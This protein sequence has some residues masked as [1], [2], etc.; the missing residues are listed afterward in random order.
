MIHQHTVTE[1][2]HQKRIDKL[3]TGLLS[4]TSRSQ[5]QS[6]ITDGYV[7]VNGKN[8]KTNYKCQT[9]DVVEWTVP[10]PDSLTIEAEQIPLE[11]VYEDNYLL[12]VNKPRGMVVHPSAG[13]SSG[14]L[15]NALLNHC[16][17]LSQING[18]ERPG[19]VHRIDK[20]T[21]GL[22]V[23]AKTDTVHRHLAD[24]LSANNVDREY[25]AIVHGV[26]DH[27][28]GIIDAPIGRDQNNRQKMGVVDNGKEAVTHFRV[29]QRFE[30]ATHIECQLETGRTHQIRVHMNYIGFPIAGD[31]KYGKRKTM[32]IDGQALHAKSLA[33]IHPKTEERVQFTVEAPPYFRDLLTQLEKI[34]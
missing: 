34:D 2:E 20:D 22:L 12:V 26:I 9:G 6:W 21:S 25:E 3:L 16:D 32:A 14:S 13:H 5:L 18:E 33:F 29:L 28:T 30:H 17:H 31:P 1:T 27:N 8:V 4:D 15:V 10:E 11:V 24:Q 19:I 23:V 7:H